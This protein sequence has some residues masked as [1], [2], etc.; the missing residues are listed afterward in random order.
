MRLV[1][2]FLFAVAAV[3]VIIT[4]FCIY[5]AYN[6]YNASGAWLD[7]AIYVGQCVPRPVPPT[8][9]AQCSEILSGAI[10]RLPNGAV[11]NL[12][13]GIQITDKDVLLTGFSTLN[14]TGFALIG[15]SA[16]IVAL[17]GIAV[18][19]AGLITVRQRVVSAATGSRSGAEDNPE[20]AK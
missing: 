12:P 15:L 2:G 16:T 13:Y 6:A 18:A 14:N 19:L 5:A 3:L 7:R 4:G 8:T 1:K 11:L 17:A 20:Q 9:M 10:F